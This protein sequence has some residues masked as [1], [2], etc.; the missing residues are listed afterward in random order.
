MEVII[1]NFATVVVLAVL[2]VLVCLSVR[3]MLK[4][5]M[6]GEK[7]QCGGSCASGHCGSG[8]S[9]C[10]DVDKIL[11]DANARLAAQTK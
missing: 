7:D 3:L 1:P 6:C 11:A 2:V 8:C 4:K 9:A 5:G 10:G